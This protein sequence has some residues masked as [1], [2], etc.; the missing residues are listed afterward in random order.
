MMSWRCPPSA[1]LRAYRKTGDIKKAARMLE[2][3]EAEVREALDKA[4][5][6]AKKRKAH[7]ER[8]EQRPRRQP[9]SLANALLST[10]T[11]LGFIFFPVT[12]AISYVIS[13]PKRRR[14]RF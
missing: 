4:D 14:R 3:S 12:L 5:K 13:P 11:V 6:M 10:I 2:V 7:Q 8:I 9:E 1:A